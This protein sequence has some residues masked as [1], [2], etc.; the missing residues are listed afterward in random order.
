MIGDWGVTIEVCSSKSPPSLSHTTYIPLFAVTDDGAPWAGLPFTKEEEGKTG[1]EEMK[2]EIDALSWEEGR[3]KANMKN[4]KLEAILNSNDEWFKLRRW[5]KEPKSRNEEWFRYFRHNKCSFK[6]EVILTC[7]KFNR[8]QRTDIEEE[9]W[10]RRE[11]V[12][13]EFM[14]SRKQGFWQSMQ[15]WHVGEEEV[16]QRGGV[17]DCCK[18][19]KTIEGRGSLGILKKYWQQRCEQLQN[20]FKWL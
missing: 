10:R 18:N 13:T 11:H 15:N 3:V 4:W 19:S 16:C 8:D 14:D 20:I 7:V 2:I 12:D 5:M 6:R 1:E 17:A 9:H